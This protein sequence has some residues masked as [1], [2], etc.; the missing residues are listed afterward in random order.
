M[1]RS[2]LLTLTFLLRAVLSGQQLPIK[3]YTVADGL[4]EDRVNGI[5]A[6]TR[7]Y[8]WIGTSGGLTRFDGYRMKTYGVEDGLPHPTVTSLLETPSGRYLIGTLR[9]LCRLEKHGTQPFTAYPLT[10]GYADSVDAFLTEPSGRILIGSHAGLFEASRGMSFRRLPVN[11]LV[12]AHIEAMARDHDGNVWISAEK[13]LGILSPDGQLTVFQ[14]GRGLPIN[15]GHAEAMLEQPPGRMWAATNVGLVLFD[16]TDGGKWH[17]KRV[18]TV[19]DGLGGND[20]LAIETDSAGRV[21]LG[22]SEGISRFA[23][24]GPLPPR[25]EN[26]GTQNG[27]SSRRITAL[28]RDAESNMWAGTDGEGVMRIARQGF[29]T[30]GVGDKLSPARIIQVMED[31]SGEILA[32]NQMGAPPRILGIF[33]GGRF[34]SFV[35]PALQ[36]GTGWGWQ[37]VLLQ[38]K[39]GEWWVATGRGLLRFKPMTA[40][41]FSAATQPILYPQ[42]KVYRIFED[43]L[44]EIWASANS[45]TGSELTRWNPTS[46]AL[47]WFRADGTATAERC[48]FGELVSAMAEDRNHGIWMGLWRG[49]LLRYADGRITRFGEAGGLPS[50]MIRSLITDHRGRLWIAASS[51]VGV[52]AEPTAPRPHVEVYDKS[53]GL[54]SNSVLCMVEDDLGTLY[55]GTP[56]GV[57]RLD[58]ETGHVRHLSPLD[59]VSYGGFSSAIRDR[60][61]GVWFSSNRGV[62]R[63]IPEPSRATSMSKVLI[64]G[65]QAGGEDYPISQLG[66][67]RIG[68]LRL[69]PSRNH[70][71]VEFVT[72]G[73]EA[74]GD[75]RYTFK[76]A[77]A[78]TSWSE[79]RAQHAV[80]YENLASGSYR[81]LVK[82]VGAEGH[83]GPNTAEVAFTI[84]PPIWRRWWFVLCLVCAT[85]AAAYGL[86]AYRMEH[87]LAMERMR[88]AIATDLHDDIGASLAQ[89]AV[90]S[91]VA[92]IGAAGNES[93][94]DAHNH[95]HGDPYK[96]GQ[97][98]ARIGNLARELTDSMNDIV[99]S[100]RSGDESLE[101]L[102][103]RM[104]ELLAEFL[105]PAGIDF[106]WHASPPQHRLRLRLNSRRQIF[107]IYKECIHNLLKHSACR[108]A[109]VTFEISDKEAVL[110][111]ADDGKGLDARPAAAR[112]GN[113]LLNMQSRAKSLGGSVGFG[114]R[115][116]GGAQITLRLPVRKRAL[117][118]AVL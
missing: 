101:S 79:P 49:G 59:G 115:S 31:R 34:R 37:Q 10:K 113:G 65:L 73:G 92:Q 7:G 9:G 109:F 13:A 116:G 54:S 32:L 19:A 14:P 103:R 1:P 2:S 11:G 111:V 29:V 36:D 28:A 53:R 91:E 76:L 20:V 50:G 27:L 106:S 98:M 21:W 81:F 95:P 66:E 118:D 90:L 102:T 88:T 104:R 72:P 55:L 64:T 39:S 33:N 85:I 48:D 42:G 45:K 112:P 44:G 56:R 22:T 46:G 71:Q 80:D 74:G 86:H 77:P 25:F 63:L 70:M 35:Q 12:G 83:E 47:S 68:G 8:I 87:V 99:W 75:L 16:Q 82:A 58:P 67:S 96:N 51:G 41:G 26:F 84:L 94:T 43:S 69:G 89:I 30:Y 4:A 18:F 15:A 5:V 40:A 3:T 61:G 38:S 117:S 107:L 6:D 52:L 105:E 114:S 60:S 78:D 62:S 57:D 97:P 108:K 17:L 23:P 100:I 24:D 93:H 110:T